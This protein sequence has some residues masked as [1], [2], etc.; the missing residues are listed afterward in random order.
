MSAT[1]K[2]R[3]GSF[4]LYARSSRVA[5]KLE[6]AENVSTARRY[7]DVRRGQTVYGAVGYRGRAGLKIC[8]GSANG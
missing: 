5:V 3:L 1:P 6:C 2:G 4:L 7:V 8:T